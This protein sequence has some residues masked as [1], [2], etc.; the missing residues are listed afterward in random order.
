MLSFENDYS[1]GATV[2]ILERLCETNYEA[3]PGYGSDNFTK[4]AKEKIKKV[5]G[6]KD[7]DVTFLVGGTQTNSVVISTILK[8][9][10]GVIAVDSGHINTHE[11]GA[12]EHAGHKVLTI[13]GEN[14][15]L[16]ASDLKNY[17]IKFY[18]DR[19]YEHMVIPGMV[20]ISYPTEYGTIY[21]KK[22]LSDIYKVCKSYELPLFIDGARLGYGLMSKKSDMSIRDIA[23]LS[24][25]FYIGGTKV[26]AFCGEAVVFTKKKAPT[27]Y[28]TSIK[29]EELYLQ[30]EGSLE[31]S[32]IHSLMTIYI[33]R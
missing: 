2:E 10:E 14:G 25:V 32:L 3:T 24:D 21:T 22:E 20:Y 6:I 9:Y 23:R 11:A 26:G 13:K 16:K 31:Y 8:D 27:H 15:K 18:K 30:K 7:G 5:C 12:I 4:S 33:L 29:R 17:L 1:T 28:V 19:A